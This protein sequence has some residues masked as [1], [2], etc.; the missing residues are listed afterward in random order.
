MSTTTSQRA[1]TRREVMRTETTVRVGARDIFL[2]EAVAAAGATRE[3]PLVLLHGG[4]PGATGASNYARNIDAFASAGYRV[5]VP[6]MPGYGR[7][8]KEL[9]HSDPFGDLALFVRALLDAHE[10]EKA[11]VVGNSY[12]GAAALRLALDR[13]DRVARLVLMGPGG[14]GTTRALPTKA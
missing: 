13:P 8:S 2:T 9:D 7:S 12:G 3:T 4:G 1:D 11:H 6:D 10:V 14:I 5:L